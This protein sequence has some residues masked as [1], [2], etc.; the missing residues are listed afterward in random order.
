MNGR[1]DT[2]DLVVVQRLE[3]LLGVA[4]PLLGTEEAEGLVVGGGAG[5]AQGH[6]GLRAGA[7]VEPWHQ[8]EGSRYRSEAAGALLLPSCR[9][10]G[11]SPLLDRAR[12]KP[13]DAWGNGL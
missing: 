2:A 9:T 13:R 3:L 1:L 6:Q 8:D 10:I 4:H 12:M 11:L 5:G 7:D